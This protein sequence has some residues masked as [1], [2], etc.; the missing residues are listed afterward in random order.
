[1]G[2]SY[3]PTK[4]FSTA[5]KHDQAAASG[6]TVGKV[7]GVI[8]AVTDV[9]AQNGLNFSSNKSSATQDHATSTARTS[10]LTAGNN[11]TVIATDGDLDSQGTQMRAEGDA[12]LL[13]QNNIN[14]DVAHNYETQSST[15][16]TKGFNLGLNLA[17][18]LGAVGT[19]NNKGNGIGATDTVVGSQLSVGGKTTVATTAGDISLT[20][21]NIVSEGDVNIN[22]AKNLTIQSGQDTV[23]NEN[24]END[25]AIGRVVISDTERFFGYHNKVHNDNADAVTQVSSNVASLNGNVNLT[26]GKDYTQT[27]SNVMAADTANV[28]AKSITLNTADNS[29][30]HHA[31]DKDLKIGTFARVSSPIID[32]INN[33]DAARQSDGRLQAMQ[34]MAAGANVYQAA[35]AISSMAG[36]AG[37]GSL[38][39]AEAGIGFSTKKNAENSTYDIAQG[40]SIKGNNINLTSTEGDIHATGANLTATKALSLDSADKIILD[41]GESTTHADG[42]RSGYGVEVGVGVSVGAQTG[43]YAYASAQAS[44]GNSKS[45]STTYN[46]THLAADTINLKSKGGCGWQVSD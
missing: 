15:S 2:I 33:V 4:A 44:K 14:L 10:S 28:T 30:T 23:T 9:L 5:Y 37:S 13:A 25:K 46:N 19:L 42:K 20:A 16:Q 26:A 6:S 11:L 12:L 24:H 3:N 31:D 41:A 21:A 18:P 43:V 40:S 17:G 7:T 32:L 34:G 8:D 35:S 27:A 38:I 39:S 1:L 29:G 45:D 22:A 36:G